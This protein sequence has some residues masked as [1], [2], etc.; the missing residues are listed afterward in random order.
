MTTRF[1]FPL[2]AAAIALT[3]APVAAQ[4]LPGAV[5]RAVGGID[6]TV[7]SVAAPL[8]GQAGGE[9]PGAHSALVGGAFDRVG[10]LASSV[11][12]SPDS[13]LDLRRLR[14]SL[15]VDAHRAELAR[16]ADG[17]IVRR[18]RLVAL[19]PDSASLA[20]AARAGFRVTGGLNQPE[21]GMRLV[22]LAIPPRMNPRK[23]LERLRDAAPA[24]DAD[25]DHVFEP[26]G[27]ALSPSSA[28]L[29]AGAAGLAPAGT[30]IAMVDGG[31]AAHPSMARA[32]IEQKGFAGPASATGH[33]T[34]VAS[35][36]VGDQGAFRGAARNASLFVADVY[37]G[38][39]AAGSASTIV[40]AL[41]WAASKQPR[42]V[43]VSLVGPAN[44]AIERAVAGLR[45]RGIMVVAAVGN[46]G[47]AAPPQYPASYEGVVAVTGVDA[48]GK[49]LAE[50][51]R[52]RHLDF[53]APGAE[54]AA[55]LP[56]KGYASVRGTSFAAPLAAARLAA[57]GSPERLAAE[58]RPGKGKV[59]RG[60]VCGECRVAPKAVGA[61]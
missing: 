12:A 3:A 48:K 15:L 24:I 18:D 47:P 26:A 1:R 51:G 36:L 27:G 5:G 54:L 14:Q 13:L 30:R 46:D 56:G 35:L 60:I 25:F 16:D 52:A 9:A 61:K 28:L 40:R 10:T 17:N 49:A 37:G 55:A 22:T 29:A 31:V 44:R 33:G 4:L 32:S 59:G 50:A 21:L 11:A 53:A 20:A 38:N 42:L 2:I 57:A 8:L 58:A 41:G 6:R 39:P 7:G 43:T 34:A 23:A 45:A 19:E